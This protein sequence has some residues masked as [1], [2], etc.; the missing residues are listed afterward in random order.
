MFADEEGGLF[1]DAIDLTK[2][3]AEKEVGEGAFDAA[4]LMLESQ[5]FLSSPRWEG[6]NGGFEF[7]VRNTSE[8]FFYVYFIIQ[9]SEVLDFFL[10]TNF[11]NFTNRTTSKDFSKCA[12]CTTNYT[13]YAAC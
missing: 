3:L 4:L 5:G 6:S 13:N 2:G 12:D 7:L 10:N 11:T 1:C 8:M 9:V